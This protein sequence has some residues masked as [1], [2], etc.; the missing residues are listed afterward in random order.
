MHNYRISGHIRLFFDYQGY[1]SVAKFQRQEWFLT[2]ERIDIHL[3]FARD[4]GEHPAA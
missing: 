3:N 4:L 2:G 1:S